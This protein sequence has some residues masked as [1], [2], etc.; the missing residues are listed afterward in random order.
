MRN[1]QQEDVNTLLSNRGKVFNNVYKLISEVKESISEEI[2]LKVIL[3]TGELKN[4]DLIRDVS[5]IVLFAGAD[6]IK[7]STGKVPVNATP[8]SVRSML[9]ALK[10]FY[11]K[12]SQ[13]K[14]L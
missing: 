2:K 8:E 9:E 12:T 1:N 6:M 11:D 5:K 4:T 13:L 10:W 3:E 7:T 14:G